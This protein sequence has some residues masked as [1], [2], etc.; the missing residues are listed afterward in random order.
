MLFRSIEESV[1][2]QDVSANTRLGSRTRPQIAGFYR[3]DIYSIAP[4]RSIISHAKCASRHV[5]SGLATN[6]LGTHPAKP[7]F[8]SQRYVVGAWSHL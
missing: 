7:L 6:R 1:K 3:P 5:A 2:L 8:E 4:Q